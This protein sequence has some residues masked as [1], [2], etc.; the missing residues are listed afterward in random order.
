MAS[1][2]I[3]LHDSFFVSIKEEEGGTRKVVVFEYEEEDINNSEDLEP[4]VSLTIN[5]ANM[6]KRKELYQEIEDNVLPFI[7]ENLK[8]TSKRR[9][10]ACE[11]KENTPQDSKKSKKEEDEMKPN[12]MSRKPGHLRLQVNPTHE[13]NICDEV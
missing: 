12:F 13:N 5:I 2:Q 1:E 9:S 8:N 7:Q 11:D 10:E 6:K 3:L 4:R